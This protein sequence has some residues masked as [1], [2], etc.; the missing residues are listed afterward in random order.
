MTTSAPKAF[1]VTAAVSASLRRP[2]SF[3]PPTR[4]RRTGYVG[5]GMSSP[6]VQP[7]AWMHT[8]PDSDVLPPVVTTAQELPLRELSW[9]NFERLCLRLA[10]RE[11]E[12]ED[13]SLYGV[14]GQNQGGIDLLA[15]LRSGAGYQVYQCK[16]V[17][18]FG[19][20]DIVAAVNKFM[21]GAW[22]AQAKEFVLCT[23]EPLH[24]ASCAD[25]IARQRE[26]L[27]PLEIGFRVWDAT[28]LCRDLKSAPEVVDDFFGRPWVEHFLGPTVA[29]DLGTR[30]DL[31]KT[32]RLRESLSK[33][34]LHAFRQHDRTLLSLTAPTPEHSSAVVLPDILESS[35]GQ[36]RE[37]RDGAGARRSAQ[38]M[39]PHGFLDAEPPLADPS[40][41][42]AVDA[43]LRIDV[44]AWLAAGTRR[45][46]V[47]GP[48][49]GKS[50]LL[51]TLAM[52]LL[53]AA[54]RMTRVA[55]RWGSH[56]PIWISFAQWTVLISDEKVAKTS[57]HDFVHR[58]VTV[59]GAPELSPLVLEALSDSRLLLLVDGLDEWST[60]QAAQV[61]VDLLC[62]F[63]GHRELPAVATARPHALG[64]LGL[65][66]ADWGVGLLAPLIERQQV[67]IAV[68]VIQSEMDDHGP[69]PTSEAA[70][71]EGSRF[72]EHVRQHPDLGRL[73][74][75]PL[76]LKLMA[77]LWSQ[78][79]ELPNSRYRAY[80]KLVDYLL[81]THPA[82]R[83]RAAQITSAPDGLSMEDLR[84]A[85][86]RLALAI[87]YRGGT[88]LVPRFRGM[89]GSFSAIFPTGSGGL[90]PPFHGIGV[91]VSREDARAVLVDFFRDDDHGR[92]LESAE[93]RR[94]SGV[95]LQY[96]TDS[97]G[98]LVAPSSDTV[99]F[100]HRALQEYLAAEALAAQ[101]QS[102]RRT[103]ILHARDAQWHEVLSLLASAL[104]GGY[105]VR[106]LIEEINREFP[107]PLDRALTAPLLA[108]IA[109]GTTMCPPKLAKQIAEA[110]IDAVEF[111]SSG[112]AGDALLDSVV[113]G[114]SNMAT[115]QLVRGRLERWLPRLGVFRDTVYTRMAEWPTSEEVVAI[116][117]RGL[118]EERTSEAR[119]AAKALVHH[120]R[121]DGN[122]AGSLL[123]RAARATT[124][125]L[126]ALLLDA[127]L[128][129]GIAIAES[130]A[131]AKSGDGVGGELD[132]VAI[133]ARVGVQQHTDRDR[134]TLLEMS[135][136]RSEIDS[137][138]RSDIPS[139]LVAGWPNSEQV[140]K[141]CLESIG[142]ARSSAVVDRDVA[143]HVLIRGYA[144][145]AETAAAL[146]SEIRTAIPK[147]DGTHGYMSFEHGSWPLIAEF[148]RNSLPIL[149]AFDDW[150]P[151]D[152]Y[153]IVEAH[154]AAITTRSNIAKREMIRRLAEGFPHWPGHALLQ[155]W[156]M[157]DEEVARVLREIAYG[158]P[159]RAEQIAVLLPSIAGTLAESRALLMSLLTAPSSSR[160]DFVVRGLA[161]T[162]PTDPEPDVVTAI[163]AA[164]NRNADDGI[165]RVSSTVIE[166]WC[167]DPRVQRMAEAEVDA[168]D[169]NI[170]AVTAA[171]AR[172][173]ELRKILSSRLG[174]LSARRRLALS[175][176]LRGHTDDA[177]VR[178]VLGRYTSEGEA[179]VRTACALAHYR[180][181][182]ADAPSITER[183]VKEAARRGPDMGAAGGAAL[184]ALLA[185]G[186]AQAFADARDPSDPT[187]PLVIISE[188]GLRFNAPLWREIAVHWGELKRAVGSDP[189]VR[190]SV[191]GDVWTFLAA[192]APHG[193]EAASDVFE[194]VRAL[195]SD[196][197]LNIPLLEFLERHAPRSARLRDGC[198]ATMRQAPPMLQEVNQVMAA[199]LLGRAF[200][201]DHETLDALLVPESSED[202]DRALPYFGLSLIALCEGWHQ[203]EELRRVFQRIKVINPRFPPIVYVPVVATMS[204]SERV[205]SITREYLMETR[206]YALTM[207]ARFVSRRLRSDADAFECLAAVASAG[208]SAVIARAFLL[209]LLVEARGLTGDLRAVC[210][211][212]ADGQLSGE[213]VPCRMLDPISGRIR[214][215]G[216][217]LVEL[218]RKNGRA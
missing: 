188:R 132:L 79:I 67:P 97:A 177:T 87:Q 19:P 54:P 200:A 214:P 82:L 68:S 81:E 149:Q 182:P 3:A 131:L 34:Y 35:G 38:R 164:I 194:H 195:P 96:A 181:A 45:L 58:W 48:G 92:G 156:G 77:Q 28:G 47:G 83:R 189:A 75:T 136:W 203:S 122:I 141:V 7:P 36:P 70:A 111:A 167:D 13:C 146:A 143:H 64:T 8:P 147:S 88:G 121:A 184:A 183:L 123:D 119:S 114:L 210:E 112:A 84:P 148:A 109:F 42:D 108:D 93:A 154:W 31:H 76:F 196:A 157:G 46:V 30:L 29:R 192:A 74:Q 191:S 139:L 135:N 218:L 166:H 173:S 160:L 216:E 62:T 25:E 1:Y 185:T 6:P 51:R 5:K 26:L 130:T 169:G 127:L 172:V 60:P 52:D 20:S 142:G 180:I 186:R 63:L 15:R 100:F 113:M 128:A 155:G 145:D 140:K 16:R 116:L 103:A 153:N 215:L 9:P 49:T 55:R 162:R 104:P 179:P 39:D 117:E 193:T 102:A 151:T 126:R 50:T 85:L 124:P 134:D 95:V 107:T 33:L 2:T 11:A 178:L 152:K 53:S 110:T 61:A 199:E 144:E 37:R 208:A 24:R 12:V 27:R 170:Y 159:Q 129:G 98:I 207:G 205:V 32:R 190:L 187:K 212:L 213:V 105:A 206:G 217:V 106:E 101:R 175:M 204:S 174:V 43:E 138:W 211:N 209:R 86:A 150:L 89:E 40:H 66:V 198:L 158:P 44:D 171:A 176:R 118:Y 17:Q 72:L 163:L 22:R 56:L 10:E 197:A 90:T 4:P 69:I 137:D 125:R 115:Q 133:R 99:S 202:I 59:L 91:L 94:T 57:L 21:G 23:S 14:P 80:Q 120:A 65:P 41:D 201:G 165:F 168:P 73:A 161:E 71:Q 78:R 18:D